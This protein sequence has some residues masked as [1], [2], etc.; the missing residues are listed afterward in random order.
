[1]DAQVQ[2]VGNVGTQVV[3][4]RRTAELDAWATFRLANTPGYR[5]GEEWVDRPTTWI[6][7]N[8][9]RALA[10]NV[11]S[12]LDVGHPVVVIGKLRTRTWAD[13]ETGELREILELE[14]DV[15]GH[16]LRSGIANFS[17]PPKHGDGDQPSGSDEDMAGVGDR[18]L[19]P[20]RGG[21][22]PWVGASSPS[23][24]PRVVDTS[25]VADVAGE[26]RT[27][28]KAPAEPAAPVTEPAAP[29]T[30]KEQPK[31]RSKARSTVN[32]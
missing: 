14:A 3:Y 1:M 10:G 31:A 4:R 9:R 8:C 13:K 32:A 24:D 19:R 28:A 18:A 12:S 15:V 16:D 22:D 27:D 7:V 30:G 5:R 21:D 17:R 26:P 29:V 11:R 2:M 20:V 23:G 6:T 25:E